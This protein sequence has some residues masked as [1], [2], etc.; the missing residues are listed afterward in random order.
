MRGAPKDIVVDTGLVT[1]F[2]S[3]SVASL[4]EL[5]V[6]VGLILAIPIAVF[7]VYIGYV[8]VRLKRR[9]LQ[10]VMEQDE[11]GG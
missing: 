3:I 8:D 2:A 9:K 1:W 6:L 11:E 5:L 4:N 7:R 10:E